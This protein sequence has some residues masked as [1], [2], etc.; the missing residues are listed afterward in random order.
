M[1]VHLTAKERQQMARATWV[2]TA[3][4]ESGEVNAMDRAIRK[5]RQ[6]AGG[7]SG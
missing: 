3:L 6:A 4:G 7:P 1:T 5:L 2:V